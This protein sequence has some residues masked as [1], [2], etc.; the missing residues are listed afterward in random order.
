VYCA[1][2]PKAG[3]TLQYN[4]VKELLGATLAVDYGW[5]PAAKFANGFRPEY[6][7]ENGRHMML[8]CHRVPRWVDD[9]P[10]DPRLRIVST[11]RDLRDV[12]A[13]AIEFQ[14][15]A[16]WDNA[17]ATLDLSVAEFNR[18]DGLGTC[19]IQRYETM[20]TDLPGTIR[21]L[22]AYLGCAPTDD[23]IDDLAARWQVDAAKERA[24]AA[25]T[26]PKRRWWQRRPAKADE[27]WDKDTLLWSTHIS[28]S[29]GRPGRYEG[30]LTADQLAELDERYGDWLRAHNY[31]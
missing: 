8:K 24:H 19:L 26:P 13:S 6:G 14:P 30:V 12:A 22:A 16:G 27:P 18:L 31:V 9:D 10:G 2:L 11:Y 7:D 15:D 28:E 4:L 25:E 17:I 23:E 5:T 3:S 21:E 1:G 29:K 20:M